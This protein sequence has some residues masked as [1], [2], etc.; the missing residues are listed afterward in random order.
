M[1]TDNKL[2]SSKA[3]IKNETNENIK[4]SI[5]EMFIDNIAPKA[6]LQIAVP[7]GENSIKICGSYG[8][9][10]ETAMFT[11]MLGCEFNISFAQSIFESG[12]VADKMRVMNL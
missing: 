8:E 11:S 7:V 1:Q 9:I 5:K 6:K 12:L 2:K 3:I 4:V 10:T